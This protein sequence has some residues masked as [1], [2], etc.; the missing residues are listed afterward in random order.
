[1]LKQAV[2][3]FK[4]ITRNVDW[5]LLSFLLFLLNIKLPVKILAIILIYLFQFNFKFNFGFRQ[6]RLPLFY[7]LIIPIAFA[8]LFI[9]QDY[10]RYNYMPVFL[11]GIGFWLLCILGV[12]Q[13][14]LI[15]ERTDVEKIHQTII[16]FFIL[17]TLVS[18]IDLALIIW[19][20]HDINPYTYRGM[21]Q[22]YFLNTGDFIKGI[23][24]DI[25]PTSAALNS[26]GVIYFLYKRNTLMMLVCMCTL[27]LI[28]CNLINLVLIFILLLL[29][30]FKSDRI[31]KST[32]V[33]CIILFGIFMIKVSP[34]NKNYVTQVIDKS[35]GV[36]QGKHVYTPTINIPLKQRPDS[37]L[38]PDEK[39][40]KFAIIYIDSVRAKFNLAHQI[41]TRTADALFGDKITIPTPDSNAA[42]FKI[43]ADI[44]PDRKMLLQFIGSNKS[45]LPISGQSNYQSILPGKAEGM[46]QTFT[47][48]KN[49]QRNIVAGLGI[50]NFSSKIAFRAT[51]LGL[52]G[53]YPKKYTYIYPAFLT[54]HLDLYINYFSKDL[55]LHSVSNNPFS[56][57][58]QL[59]SEYGVLGLLALLIFYFGFFLK[60]Y[61][62]LSYGLPLLLFIFAIFFI[63]YWFEQLSIMIMLELMLF[64]NIKESE[65]ST[66]KTLSREQ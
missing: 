40:R 44:E 42:Q 6:S 43:S 15:V 49:H 53:Q 17:N 3:S 8:G 61:K 47:Y 37:L 48:L 19:H 50:G 25:A 64:L 18:V 2:L 54:N 13:V 45:K 27:L 38:S 66:S 41:K 35:F 62:K 65:L 16:V 5:K 9:N 28:Y 10:L 29:L 4:N 46:L 59:L 1:M 7:L 34:Q 23:S 21:Y 33:M 31:Q 57:Y 58:D 24:F 26:F 20:T 39:R 12:H 56:V 14:K 52:R 60:Q 51:G 36:K 11:T 32:I 55:G 22:T 30:I 63:D